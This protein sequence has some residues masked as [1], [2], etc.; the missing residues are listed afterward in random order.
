MASGVQAGAVVAGHRLL[1]EIGHGASS[2]VFLAESIAG[3]D[4]VALKLL[5]LPA[6]APPDA[7]AAFLRSADVARRLQHP[8][9][10][11]VHAAG[12]DT[13]TRLAWLAMEAVPGSDLQRYTQKARLLPEPVALRVARAVAA[14][15]DHAHRQ[16]VVHRD[17]KPANV[18]VD[19]ASSTVK[20]GDF[21]LA[22]PSGAQQ[23]ATGLLL[24][25][26][27][28][29]A[30]E[31]L[32]GSA[33]TPRSDLYALGVTLFEL[34]CGRRPHAA[35][36]M[37]ELL[38]NVAAHPA[39]ALRSVR[40]DLP[41]ALDA[42]LGHLLAARPDGRPRDAAAVVDALDATIAALDARR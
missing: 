28:Y 20:L 16:G 32:A 26:P 7:A 6:D 17:L 30:P 11:A 5:P 15:L 35:A 2:R 33:P 1:R 12:V 18:L 14:A 31:Q 36:T 24:G 8:H 4:A 22:R 38:R 19:W 41:P 37:G 10:V 40:P 29:M 25:T 21:G 9:I 39:P 27:A 23:T 42:L 13:A 3:G 34:L